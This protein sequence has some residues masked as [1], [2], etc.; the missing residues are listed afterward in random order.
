MNEPT[1]FTRIINGEIPSHKIYE[2]EKTFCF[3]DI[4]PT[5]EGHVLVVPKV[6]VEFVWDLTPE[7]HAALYE[8]VRKVGLRLREVLGVPYVSERVVG[9]DVPHAHVHVLPFTTTDQLHAEGRDQ[10]EPDHAA[11][12]VLAERLRFE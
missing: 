9:T 5:T 6:E 1:L 4:Y 3:L 12:A 8:T 2:D 11:L 10:V 7:D